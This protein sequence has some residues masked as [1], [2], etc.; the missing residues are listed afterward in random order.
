MKWWP[1]RVF[2]FIIAITEVNTNLAHGWF[3]GPEGTKKA[4]P[5]IEFRKKLAFEMMNNELDDDGHVG[6]S[7]SVKRSRKRS[8]IVGH[9]FESIP[10]FCGQWVNGSWT[11]VGTKYLQKTCECG[12]L[13]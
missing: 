4:L 1:N 10:P 12:N 9:A 13:T 8:E 3:C 11:K 6:E 2:A 7:P 5:S